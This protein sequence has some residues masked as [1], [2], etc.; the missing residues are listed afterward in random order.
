MAKHA[1]GNTHVVGVRKRTSIGNSF[2]S[3]DK[4]KNAKSRNGSRFT[5]GQGRP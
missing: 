1:S 3:G 2:R 5:R 4:S